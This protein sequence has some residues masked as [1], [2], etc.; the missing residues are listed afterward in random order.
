[1]LFA[2]LLWV[3]ARRVR[4][5]FD[6]DALELFNIKGP[7]LD[8]ENG[9]WLQQKPDNYVTG[10]RNRWRYDAITNYGFFPSIEF[11]VIMYFKE[12]D[13]PKEKWNRWFAAFDS[14]GRGQPHFL[15]GI[16][17]AKQFKA[18]LEKRG[19]KHKPIPTLKKKNYATEK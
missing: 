11:P 13:T 6:K 14:Y 9:A 7:H 5:V 4:C 19:V 10:T 1:M 2:A 18:E 17:D 15:P 16:V 3:Q 8:L 12:T